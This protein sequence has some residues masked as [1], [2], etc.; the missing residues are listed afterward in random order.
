MTLE[1]NDGVDEFK[2]QLAQLRSKQKEDEKK[3]GDPTKRKDRVNAWVFTFNNPLKCNDTYISNLFSMVRGHTTK[4]TN[5][6]YWLMEQKGIAH[7]EFGEEWGE[8]GTHHY[9]GF[10]VFEYPV[11]FEFVKKHFG[12]MHLDKMRGLLKQ[13]IAYVGKDGK[14]SKKTRPGW[15]EIDILNMVRHGN[16]KATSKTLNSVSEYRL[17]MNFLEEKHQDVLFDYLKN[18]NELKNFKNK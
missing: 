16:A 3:M 6:A 11:N 2:F 14:V 15:D 5:K 7:I 13:N 9:Q 17:L 12:P 8:S 4:K 18:Y 10:L 1:L